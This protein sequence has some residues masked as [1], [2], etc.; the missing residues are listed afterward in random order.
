M[1]RGGEARDGQREYGFSF[2]ELMVTLAVLAVLASVAL[3]LA[4]INAQRE[5]ERQLRQSLVDI[6]EAIDAYKKASDLGRI[7]RK[8]GESG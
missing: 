5:K 7:A 1:R 3:P 2:I 6:R 4:Q 8:V